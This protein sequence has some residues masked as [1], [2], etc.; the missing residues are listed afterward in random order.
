MGASFKDYHFQPFIGDAIKDLGF[1]NPT[2]IQT[3]VIPTIKHGKSVIGKSATGSGKTHAFLLPIFDGLDLNKEDVQVVITTPSRELAY[4]IYDNAKQI[5]KFSDKT[6]HIGN[7]VGGTDKERQ[8]EKL[9]REQPQVVIGTPGRVWDLVKNGDLEIHSAHQLVIDEADMTLD[10]GFLDTVDEIASKMAEDLQMMVFS[11]TVPP[12][13]KPFLKKYMKNPV[14]NDIPTKTVINQNVSN[15]LIST[16]G[17]NKNDLIYQLITMGEP[18]LV[19]IFANTRERVDEIYN[20][21]KQ[22][23]LKVA[24]I[25]GGMQPR[26]RKRVMKQI[27]NLDYQFVVASDL[28]ARGIDI[29]GVSHVINDDIPT[30]LEYFIHRVGR[31]GRNGMKGI[32]M[33]LYAPGE[34][35]RV[36]ELEKMGI[37]FIPKEIKRGEVVD[38]YDR[39][40]RMKRK[41]PKNKLD[42]TMIGL[43]KKKKKNVKPGYKRKIKRAIKQKSDKDRKIEV[44]NQIRARKKQKK[45]SSQR[46]Q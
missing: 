1:R 22:Q 19:L 44:R 12:K 2:P 25:H 27:Q 40:R 18:Y 4:Q 41:E 46:Y 43:I 7:Y 20:Y 16:K 42:P 10:L 45:R 29:S 38:T 9:E 24:E 5:A 33:T 35:Q 14:M 26:V 13:L 11:A 15:W 8:V 6:I 31:T 37:K 17:K 3:K 28:A 21:L 39:R 23:G 32:A 30:D 34:E 36:S